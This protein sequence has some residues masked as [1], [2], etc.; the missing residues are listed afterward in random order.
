MRCSSGCDGRVGAAWLVTGPILNARVCPQR[1]TDQRMSTTLRIGPALLRELK[2]AAVEDDKKV[3]DLVLKGVH[4]VLA[5][6][7]QPSQAQPEFVSKGVPMC[8][9][10]PAT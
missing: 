5:L 4:Y 1:L 9:P 10:M 2:Y 3:N 7:R 6:R 8:H